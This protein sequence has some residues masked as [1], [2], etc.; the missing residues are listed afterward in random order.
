L[1]DKYIRAEKK[2]Q[3]ARAIVMFSLADCNRRK[4]SAVEQ[5]Q[6]T[7]SRKGAKAQRKNAKLL[8]VS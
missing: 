3:G 4:I 7:D 8:N 5:F 1:Q 2:N 6:K